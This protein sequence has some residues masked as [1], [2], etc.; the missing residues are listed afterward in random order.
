ME[1]MKVM[2]LVERDDGGDLAAL[3]GSIRSIIEDPAL[4]RVDKNELLGVTCTQ[5][6][7][8][9]GRNALEDIAKVGRLHPKGAGPV[10]DRLD[11]LTDNY[12]RAHPEQTREMHRAAGWSGLSDAERDAIRAEEVAHRDELLGKAD[13]MTNIEKSGGNALETMQTLAKILRNSHPELTEAQA[14]D[15]VYSDPANREL[16]RAERDGAIAK[17]YRLDAAGNMH[18]I[19]AIEAEKV[20]KAE[21][22]MPAGGG[23]AMQQLTRLAKDRQ[24][25]THESF[26]V[27]FDAIYSAPDNSELRQLEK[28]ERLGI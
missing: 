28:S 20:E 12:R 5:Y 15:K 27:A 24:Q 21:S 19:E 3:L 26:A 16:V 1:K 18:M 2:K 25:R 6:C 7:E 11:A 8:L 13:G 9:T 22:L 10:H 23:E 17:L 14:F 4:D